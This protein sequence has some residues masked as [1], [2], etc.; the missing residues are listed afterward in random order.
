MSKRLGTDAGAPRCE[1]GVALV[2]AL[3]FLVLLTIIGVTAMR[4]ATLQERMAGNARERNAALQITEAGLRAAE[5]DIVDG[6]NPGTDAY[7]HGSGGGPDW[8]E[9]S[10]SDGTV[11]N[12]AA[13]ELPSDPPGGDRPCYSIEEEI[14]MALDTSDDPEVFY[15]VTIRGTG[16]TDDSVVILRSNYRPAP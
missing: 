3:V 7:V 12:A 14:N 2:T 4:T 6:V 11:T 15:E 8:D 16:R 9:F 5:Q 10:C 13:S 1:R